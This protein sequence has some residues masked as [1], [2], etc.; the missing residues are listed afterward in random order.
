MARGPISDPQQ[1][2]VGGQEDNHHANNLR[3]KPTTDFLATVTTAE[4]PDIKL[5]S[6][7][8]KMKTSKTE[9]NGGV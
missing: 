9:Y 2:E 1:E 4:N 5:A 3:G 7:E 8:R 6:V